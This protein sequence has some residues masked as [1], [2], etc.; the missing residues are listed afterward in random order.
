MAT[1]ITEKHQ[2]EHVLNVAFPQESS[3]NL[4]AK[5]VEASPGSGLTETQVDSAVRI[6][7]Q[8]GFVILKGVLSK[9]SAD[10][11]HSTCEK[12]ADC[13]TQHDPSRM[14]NRNP[15][16][17]SLGGFQCLRLPAFAG[18]LLNCEA[19]IDVLDAIY[20]QGAND[21]P[22]YFVKKAGGDYCCGET[23]EFQKIHSDM[24]PAMPLAPHLGQ[25][26]YGPVHSLDVPPTIS[27]NYCTAPLHRWNGPMRIIDWDQMR[28]FGADK[29]KDAPGLE[30]E[31]ESRPQWLASK[32]FPLAA[33]DVVVRDIRA[34]HGGCPNLS[35]SDRFL[36]ALEVESAAKFRF[37][38]DADASK[39][40][41]KGKSKR[42]LQER[43]QTLPEQFFMALPLRIQRLCKYVRAPHLEPV[44]SVDQ[45]FLR[46][47]VIQEARD[48]FHLSCV[49]CL[50][51]G[52]WKMLIPKLAAI[53][54]LVHTV[55]NPGALAKFKE[56]LMQLEHASN[57]P[58]D[59]ERA[60]EMLN[61]SLSN[62]IKGSMLEQ[63]VGA[64][65]VVI[66]K[67]LVENLES[68]PD[69]RISITTV[70]KGVHN[71]VRLVPNNRVSQ[72]VETGNGKNGWTADSGKI[73]PKDSGRRSG[74]ML[75]IRGSFGFIQQ[76]HGDKM[77]ILP[78]S[79]AGFGGKLPPKGTRLTY[80]VVTD[81]KTGKPRA[82]DVYP[83]DSS[84]WSRSYTA[85]AE[86]SENSLEE[87]ARQWSYTASSERSDNSKVEQVRRW[88]KRAR[89]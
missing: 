43:L 27:V 68:F 78:G 25:A 23:A 75:E 45:L 74:V 73:E 24:R 69:N 83:E 80:N 46:A 14:G 54:R 16:R 15:G 13:I 57:L 7:R 31:L 12:L 5:T 41:G 22:L 59:L 38:I 63:E 56:W 70:S 30:Q 21:E 66:M 52:A 10:E 26:R 49:A 86:R 71:A 77:F 48:E 3:L 40:K 72:H 28:Q 44:R 11:V 67:W 17:Y 8:S 65:R 87:Y 88:S 58:A 76:D 4:S 29:G 36:P 62:G 20:R 2:A 39:G 18:H 55:A 9:A 51:A 47:K 85:S 1:S 37:D 50:A 89:Y 34:W 82:D 42:S 32:L 61:D 35:G 33:G 84:Q 79:C 53:D 60:V 64:P 81:Q 6:F 19:V